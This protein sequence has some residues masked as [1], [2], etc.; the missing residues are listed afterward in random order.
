NPTF[1]A[2]E[3]VIKTTFMF[4]LVVN[5]G[6]I[7][8]PADQLMVTVYPSKSPI[9]NAPTNQIVDENSLITLDGSASSDPENDKFIYLWTAPS[10]I[11][12]SSNTISKPTLLTP[13]VSKDTTYTVSLL[14]KDD[15]QNSL[16]CQFK[17]SVM[18]LDKAPYVINPI[19]NISVDKTAPDQIIDLQ[20]V[21][22]DDD[23]GDV[24]S[25][26]F[27]SN[28]NNQV[29]MTKLTGCKLAL[30]FSTQN[31]GSSEISIA[32]TSNGKE[33][34][35]KFNV[36]VKIPTGI[37][38]ITGDQKLRVFPNPAIG[39]VKVE[40][41]QVPAMGMELIV[42][43]ING[44]TILRQVIHQKEQWVD[45][46]GNRPGIYLLKTNYGDLNVQKIILR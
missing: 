32:A 35:A 39:K 20:T 12:L 13:E 28:T 4:S 11:T 41:D 22:A 46:T 37:T 19:E 17:I 27:Y 36:E 9:F 34:I 43:D 1:T 29:V 33:A 31:I 6:H 40:L 18:N 25:Y 8:S 2:P 45:L 16:T 38:S 14:V 21:F 44:K 23:W 7:D 42:T 10:G 30:S 3:V 5:D 15:F 26:N 24:L